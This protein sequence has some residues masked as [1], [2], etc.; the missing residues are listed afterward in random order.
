MKKL[1]AVVMIATLVSGCAGIYSGVVTMTKIRDSAMKELAQLHKQGKI[2]ATTDTK[3]AEAD[4][5]YRQAAEV[6]EKAL[7]AYQDGGDKLQYV[8][9]LQAVRAAVG[10]ILDILTPF[11]SQN[12]AIDM[13]ADLAKANSL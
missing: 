13:Q 8:A 2:S 3:I 6:A 1:L 11:V 7:I 4:L 5:K 10:G 12:T 9:A